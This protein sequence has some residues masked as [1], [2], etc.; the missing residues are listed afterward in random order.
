MSDLVRHS[1][2]PR[3]APGYGLSENGEVG[4]DAHVNLGYSGNSLYVKAVAPE[5]Q[6]VMLGDEDDPDK[7]LTV[8]DRLRLLAYGL[9]NPEGR[10]KWDLF[11]LLLLVWVCFASPLIVCFDLNASL[12]DH[13]TLA[14]LEMTVDMIF[15]IDIT[16]NFR[17]AYYDSM[18][19]LVTDRARIARHYAR[20]WFAFDLVSVVPFDL[21]T[22]GTLGFLSM[23][24]LLRVVRVGQV[25]RTLRMYRLMRVTRLPR[26][27][28]RIEQWLDKGVLQIMMFAMA[29]GLLAH[30]SACLFFYMAL[31]TYFMTDSWEGTWVQKQDLVD[32]SLA[33][34]YVNS[35]YWAFTTVATVGY[36]DITPTNQ[37]EKVMAILV[38][39]S[40][41]TLVGYVTSSIT[42]LMGIRHAVSTKT[43]VKKQAVNDVLKNRQV[44]SA[45]ARRVR[46]F[47]N[48]ESTKVIREDEEAL[49]QDLPFKLRSRFLQHAYVDTLSRL[50]CFVRLRPDILIDVIA[51]L[52]CVYYTDGDIIS[53][54]GDLVSDMFFI[55][56]GKMELRVYDFPDHADP[57][58]VL[59]AVNKD[60]LAGYQ[61][62]IQ[63]RLKR[64]Y[65]FGHASAVHGGTWPGT[66]V[67]RNCCEL[68]SLSHE[69]IQGLANRHAHALG[70]LLDIAEPPA[71]S[72]DEDPSSFTI[73]LLRVDI[74]P[75]AIAAD[76]PL[77]D[78]PP[79]KSG[80]GHLLG[81]AVK[82]G[83]GV[84]TTLS[85][86]RTTGDPNQEGGPGNDPNNK[87]GAGGGQGMMSAAQ[88][89]A[90]LAAAGLSR[91]ASSQR[92]L[93][94]CSSM[95]QQ[96]QQQ[97]GNE[98]AP[99]LT[100]DTSTSA[101]VSGGGAPTAAAMARTGLLASMLRRSADPQG[102]HH[103]GDAG[104]DGMEAGVSDTQ[105][106][107]QR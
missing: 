58:A 51:Q 107:L 49:L 19:N 90:N 98:S 61:Y 79:R 83:L 22:T 72:R 48:Y 35:I 32:A 81:A 80:L 43:A 67:A 15:V 12:S 77:L 59:E 4:G 91:F 105:P 31:L 26:I 57:W 102:T 92:Q 23:L 18:G 40:G 36:G 11:I 99:L 7:P 86:H 96:Q 75:E 53:L 14:W 89:K 76:F 62:T 103:P 24:K 65:H 25:M 42:K 97:P 21:L 27:L 2:L 93:E 16:L 34:Q 68:F 46:A 5:N 84:L 38:M 10:T 101:P 55:H 44:P 87:G 73:N 52:K 8:S 33:H 41:V 29:V 3:S 88:S 85:I 60:E 6:A 66:V 63:G 69:A 106:L 20:T 56:E 13:D 30:L 9:I 1:G 47:F 70:A 64:T 82:G 50:P 37:K 94:T 45:L 71:S 78:P 28:D 74:D 100:A 104:V 54:Q 39:A 95:S 17:T